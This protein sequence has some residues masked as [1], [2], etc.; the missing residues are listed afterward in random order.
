M[1]AY[2]PW[3]FPGVCFFLFRQNLIIKVGFSITASAKMFS[4]I[5]ILLFPNNIQL[6]SNF[7]TQKI[8]IT[9]IALSIFIA[10]Q[11]HYEIQAAEK[12]GS[13][14]SGILFSAN[15]DGNIENCL[16]G[17][18]PKGGLDRIAGLVKKARRENPELIWI[19][20]GDFFNTYP[21][22]ELNAGIINIY[23]LLSPD[24]LILGDQEFIEKDIFLSQ[25]VNSFSKVIVGSNYHIG[26]QVFNYS[27]N[28]KTRSGRDIIIM[29]FLDESAFEIYQPPADLELVNEAFLSQFKKIDK[30]TI[31]VVV[32]HGALERLSWFS[33][34]FG[35]ADLILLAHDQHI[36]EDVRTVPAV[37]GG[38]SDGELL[39]HVQVI[40]SNGRISFTAEKIPIEIK[41]PQD[42]EV[43]A[44]ISRFKE[45]IEKSKGE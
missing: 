29:S 34:R 9:A 43:K 6:F 35:S 10:F 41:L 20:G 14:V 44:L 4:K 37:V 28:Y 8:L 24:A 42:F 12:S 22:R 40:E 39:F 33:N 45:S 13:V 15:I 18:Q 5:E 7:M 36:I 30:Q 19:D 27:Q 3:N 32:F 11:S 1:K 38:G 2:G 16:C 21:F 25:L 17:P 26:R 31:R 23:R